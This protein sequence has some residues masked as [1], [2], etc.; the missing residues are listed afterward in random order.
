[1][2]GGSA[3]A[4][5]G[6]VAAALLEKLILKPRTARRLARIR[7]DCLRLIQQDADAFARVIRT[8]RRRDR[9]AFQQALKAATE[10]PC[11]VFEHAQAIQ[12]ACRSA[13]RSVRPR[14]QS[15][16]RCAMAI[17]LAAAES[18]RTLVQTNLA[19]LND[20]RY[21]ARIRRKLQAISSRHGRSTIR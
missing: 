18:A 21:T 4:L 10:M 6:A 9:S 14:F 2:G 3:A 8:T 11:L 5:S 15:D 1:M 16:L 20:Q 13:Q 19:W 7:R 17:A 12:A